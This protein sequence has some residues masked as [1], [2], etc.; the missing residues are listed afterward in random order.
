L[1]SYQRLIDETI[2][3]GTNER[4]GVKNAYHC[5]YLRVLKLDP[6][7]QT[8]FVMVSMGHGRAINIE[9]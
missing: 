2:D 5:N 9:I 1:L 3:T 6:I 4:A 7:I 8:E